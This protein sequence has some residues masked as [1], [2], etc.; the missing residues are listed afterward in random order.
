[1]IEQF[2]YFMKTISRFSTGYYKTQVLD[3]VS[4]HAFDIMMGQIAFIKGSLEAILTVFEEIRATSSNIAENSSSIKTQ[5]NHLIEGNKT[6]DDK[7]NQRVKE[8]GETGKKSSHILELFSVL[9]EKSKEIKG[10]TGKIQAVSKKTNVLAINTSI[11]ASKAG[12]Q[13]TGF[14]IIAGEIRK[15]AEQTG[16]FTKEIDKT[17]GIFIENVEK[18]AAYMKSFS[19]VL[20]NF[21]G[22][23]QEIKEIFLA[24]KD[25]ANTVGYAVEMIAQS[26]QE[27]S[28]A[29]NEGLQ[30][31]E[32]IYDGANTA[33]NVA[34]SIK[35]AYLGLEKVLTSR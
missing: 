20:T 5:M 4:N 23:I 2:R 8:I 25:L 29:L 10:V 34:S 33:H 19:G 27:E 24:N 21:Q 6:I 35:K 1:M 7:L 28:F 15:L 16:D 9:V 3:Y 11:E 14:N 32:L 22:D 17:I 26:T 18:I 12:A 30:K 13:G 31:L